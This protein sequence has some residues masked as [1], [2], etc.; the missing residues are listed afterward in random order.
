MP[1]H[2]L[3]T[4]LRQPGVTL[5]SGDLLF[6][7]FIDPEFIRVMAERNRG[8]D[9]LYFNEAGIRIAFLDQDLFDF[10]SAVDSCEMHD[11]E[12]KM[13]IGPCPHL[14]VYNGAGEI[15]QE[16]ESVYDIVGSGEKAGKSKTATPDSSVQHDPPT[17]SETPAKESANTDAGK[18]SL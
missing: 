11:S 1:A 4:L 15:V 17:E 3:Q 8:T 14:V 10:Q 12:R 5:G 16:L 9:N 13:I 6:Q 2:T 7:G 18:P